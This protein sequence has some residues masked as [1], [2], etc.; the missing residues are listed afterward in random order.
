MKNHGRDWTWLL[1]PIGGLLS[2]SLSPCLVSFS[3]STA[4]LL[5]FSSRIISLLCPLPGI[6]TLDFSIKEWEREMETRFKRN[7]NLESKCI[8]NER[9]RER[10]KE[11]RWDYPLHP[12]K[13]GDQRIVSNIW[14]REEIC[15]CFDSGDNLFLFL[16]LRIERRFKCWPKKRE[17]FRWSTFWRITDRI[18]V[19]F[20]SLQPIFL[21]EVSQTENQREKSIFTVSCLLL[22]L[23][24]KKWTEKRI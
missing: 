12:Q 19:F 8:I 15:C 20:V 22:Q 23:L 18:S 6:V 7:A 16:T 21:L 3:R 9:E 5:D 1:M 4:S 17:R 14:W 13:W 2:V 11:I 24:P 10:K